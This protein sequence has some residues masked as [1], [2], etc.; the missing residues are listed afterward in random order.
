MQ[1]G[2]EDDPKTGKTQSWLALPGT[3]PYD[4]GSKTVWLPAKL[5]YYDGDDKKVLV[6][7]ETS[8]AKPGQPWT[9]A[10]QV[11][12]SKVVA[13]FNGKPIGSAPKSDAVFGYA[14][15]S[16]KAWSEIVVEGRV[17]P[18]WIQSKIDAV[19]EEKRKSFEASFDLKQHL[20]AWLYEAGA[21][22]EAP[23]DDASGFGDLPARLQPDFVVILALLSKEDW[24]SALA[25]LE[26]FRA[27]G[28]PEP[29]VALLA[30]RAHVGLD[31]PTEA[32]ADIDHALAGAADNVELLELKARIL[33]ELGREA[34][35]V[36][37]WKAVVARPGAGVDVFVDACTSLLY[38]G[39][40]EAARAISEEASK[41]GLRSPAL[42]LLGR[43]LVQSANGPTWPKTFEYKSTNYH[44]SSDIDLE[45]CR[46]AAQVL[47][48]A[49][50]VYRAQVHALKAEKARLYRVFLFS[51]EAGFGRYMA[52]VTALSRRK[53]ENVA[54]IYSGLLKQLLIWNVPNREEMMRVVR[55]E[56]FHQYLDRLLPDPPVW[57]N[58]GM[59]VY[60][61][62]MDRVG[63]ALETGKPRPDDLARLETEPLTPVADFLRITPAAFY[64]GSHHSYAQAWLLVH[65]LK[66]GPNKYR[67]LYK[68]LMAKLE[69]M[70]GAEAVHAVFD[71]KGLATL[72]A[73]LEA[74]RKSLSKGR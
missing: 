23:A 26:R 19:V 44:V 31:E 35:S 71:E 73:D 54:G 22:P 41:R 59:A 6:E 64:A 57:L 20:P 58:E 17:E 72:D 1:V 15:L 16:A 9:L 10:M 40:P 2:L 14:V 65:L 60:F 55:H 3:P 8:L 18:S 21:A 27:A 33:D 56:G 53:P 66:H 7:K 13:T 4:E 38:A 12:R 28:A 74:Y 63:G 11:G 24:P 37:A 52:V 29:L 51:G 68:A 32:L 62:G 48:E 34:E 36:A 45:T 42:D 67:D 25:A 50:T 46:Q 49:L 69:T 43:V 39:Q 47:E 30:A 70:G 5:I 61:E